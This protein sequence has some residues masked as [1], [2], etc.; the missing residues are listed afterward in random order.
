MS[1]ATLRTKYRENSVIVA[2]LIVDGGKRRFVIRNS[3]IWAIFSL[4]GSN[5]LFLVRHESD[6]RGWFLVGT[7]AAGFLISLTGGLMISL[8]TWT[9]YQKLTKE[10]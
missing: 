7:E 4:L 3:L 10:G 8:T 5:A 9:R 6:L 2:R 1:F